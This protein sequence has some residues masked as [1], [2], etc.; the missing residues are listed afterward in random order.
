MTQNQEKNQPQKQ[1]RKQREMMNLADNDFNYTKI[2]LKNEHRNEIHIKRSNGI[3]ELKIIISEI[4]I[5]LDWENWT[6]VWKK[7]ETRPAT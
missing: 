2:D 4:K 7:K 1:N 6:G 5:S 3:L